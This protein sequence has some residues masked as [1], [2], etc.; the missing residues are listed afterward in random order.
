MLTAKSGS[1][2]VSALPSKIA[3]AACVTI[4]FNAPGADPLVLNSLSDGAPLMSTKNVDETALLYS[5]YDYIRFKL[6]GSPVDAAKNKIS[7]VCCG[8]QD[9]SFNISI[10]TAGSGT[11]LRK[12]A[13]QVARHMIPAKLKSKYMLK[14]KDIGARPDNDAF[15]HAARTIID[16]IKK[17]LSIALTGRFKIDADKVKEIAA[18]ANG[19]LEVGSSPAGKARNLELPIVPMEHAHVSCSDAISCILAKKYAESVL[20][21]PVM[22]SGDKLHIPLKAASK[23]AAA[24]TKDRVDQFVKKFDKLSE[25]GP[26]FAYIVAVDALASADE[27]ETI[28]KKSSLGD[29]VSKIVAALSKAV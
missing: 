24:A 19:K 8:L 21:H 9:K 20:S 14:M 1:V 6:T 18:A 23:V 13:N 10:V 28:A 27:L 4:S 12:I 7:K 25:V 2:S 29:N 16:N 15:D 17:G 22:M 26:I 3:P 11:A 5:L